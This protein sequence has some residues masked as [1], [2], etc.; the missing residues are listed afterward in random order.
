VRREVVN[1]LGEDLE[2]D[3]LQEARLNLLRFYSDKCT[4]HATNILTVGIAFFA[5][6]EV[7][8]VLLSPLNLSLRY[9][10]NSFFVTVL[11]TVGI[12]QILRLLWWSL[13]TSEAIRCNPETLEE[14]SPK[15]ID[16]PIWKLSDACVRS[17]HD[18]TLIK[19]Y[20]QQK[21]NLRDRIMF[22]GV[23]WLN[24]NRLWSFLAIGV[25][26]FIHFLVAQVWLY[27]N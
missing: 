13:S 9:L 1:K 26:L 22:E 16:N 5:Y 10:L 4:A 7:S 19:G 2:P 21:H 25:L 6:V 14:P 18:P 23:V 11:V 3:R 24:E 12:Y 8:G 20:A 15:E 17:L 27:P